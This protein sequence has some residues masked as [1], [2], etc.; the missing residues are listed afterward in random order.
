MISTGTY[1]SIR[2]SYHGL[3]SRP[4]ATLH[5]QN[6][7]MYFF[8]FNMLIQIISLK[9]KISLVSTNVNTRAIYSGYTTSSTLISVI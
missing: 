1:T 6:K 9:Y 2:E 3:Q 8:Y 7:K 4:N 5:G